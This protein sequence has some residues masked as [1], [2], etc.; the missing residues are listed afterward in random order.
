MLE[1]CRGPVNACR[2]RI[3][4]A[5]GLFVGEAGDVEI[6]F[7]KFLRN[8]FDGVFLFEVDD[9]LIDASV[10]S[11]NG[12]DGLDIDFA[13]DVSVRKSFFLFNGDD[14]I[15]VDFV[16]S[17]TRFAVIAHG[18]GDFDIEPLDL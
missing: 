5:N 6:V 9:V 3:K 8:G 15:D 14:G 10:A 11:N 16:D 17:F 2:S 12:E 13:G 4:I 7:S 18:N 1:Y